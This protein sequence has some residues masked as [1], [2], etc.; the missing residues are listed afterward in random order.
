MAEADGNRT[1]LGTL[2]PTPILKVGP[3]LLL[4]PGPVTRHFVFR[5]HA[6]TCKDCELD[7]A[8]RLVRHHLLPIYPPAVDLELALI[9]LLI[10]TQPTATGIAEVWSVHLTS[11]YSNRKIQEMIN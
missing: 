4:P 11:H 2:A 7:L 1:R 3:L 8:R 6:R 10:R 5:H 9:V